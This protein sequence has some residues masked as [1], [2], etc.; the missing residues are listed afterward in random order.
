MNISDLTP[1]E[2]ERMD[3]RRRFELLRQATPEQR[4]RLG[5]FGDEGEFADELVGPAIDPEFAAQMRQE[6]G[7][8]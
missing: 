5:Y 2:L 8:E 1:A 6:M 3:P 4:V 7:I